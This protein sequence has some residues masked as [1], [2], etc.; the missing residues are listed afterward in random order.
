MKYV[1]NPTTLGEKL[2]NKRLELSLLQKDV[3]GI[4]GVS[5]D[6]ITY[7]ENERA[8]PQVHLYPKVI[9]FLDY[10]PFEVDTSTLG[11]KIK[12]YRFLHGISQE[13]LAKK[14]GVNESSVFHYENGKH[15]PL[16]VTLKK[17]HFLNKNGNCH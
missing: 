2:R 7:W 5:E 6:T 14:L 11:G 13:G 8:T 9:E 3:A 16:L 10:F 15:K 1:T 17:M 4:I 12:K